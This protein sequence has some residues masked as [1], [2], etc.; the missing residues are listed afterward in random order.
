MGD[1]QNPGYQPGTGQFT[2][3]I[4]Y[5]TTHVG[6]SRSKDGSYI[7]ANY[8]PAGN[9]VGAKHFQKNVLPLN[10]PFSMRPR[11]KVEAELFAQFEIIS[12]GRR[13][14]PSEEVEAL[15]E[16]MGNQRLADAARTADADGD[17]AINP[18]EFV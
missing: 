2:S 17:G 6:M 4:W 16:K 1:F 14:V 8:Y 5:N 12:K 10:T 13:N 9:I 18:I 3:L 15:F 11:N 7:V